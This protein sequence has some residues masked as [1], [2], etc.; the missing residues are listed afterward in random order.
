MR[1]NMTASLA[2]HP[3]I[4]PLS[5]PVERSKFRNRVNGL[6]PT[7]R[8]PSQ[9]QFGTSLPAA[10]VP[11][12]W[13]S[14]YAGSAALSQAKHPWHLTLSRRKTA[15]PGRR[16]CKS[17]MPA[18]PKLV[19]PKRGIFLVAKTWRFTSASASKLSSRTEDS[20]PVSQISRCGENK[21]KEVIKGDMGMYISHIRNI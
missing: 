12:S 20:G 5:P 21:L 2:H 1:S 7:K 14:L 8:V 10:F 6:G 4:V 13:A 15:R 3:S 16:C 11:I 19:R 17:R 18:S 9:P